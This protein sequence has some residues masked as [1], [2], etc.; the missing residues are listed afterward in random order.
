MS[1]YIYWELFRVYEGIKIWQMLSNK[2]SHTFLEWDILVLM[3]IRLQ[4]TISGEKIVI[5]LF[6]NGVT[7]NSGWQDEFVMQ[8]NTLD[9]QTIVI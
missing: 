5:E 4:S 3:E 8:A 2:M 6:Q 1:E 7:N 9:R